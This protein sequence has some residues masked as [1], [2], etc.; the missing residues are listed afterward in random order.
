M[1]PFRVP[2]VSQVVPRSL[3][4]ISCPLEAQGASWTRRLWAGEDAA[5]E[6]LGRGYH[7]DCFMAARP[8][9]LHQPP[10]GDLE[11]SSRPPVKYPL[12]APAEY[13]GDMAGVGEGTWQHHPWERQIGALKDPV[14]PFPFGL[15]QVSFQ[16]QEGKWGQGRGTR[17]P[18][19]AVGEEGSLPLLFPKQKIHQD[20]FQTFHQPER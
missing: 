20:P 3:G 5:M 4:S 8:P 12:L 9:A 2:G 6:A 1:E 10:R 18:H 19:P 17:N 13:T 14:L 16:A 11:F 15:G 7:R